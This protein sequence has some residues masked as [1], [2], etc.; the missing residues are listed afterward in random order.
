[1]GGGDRERAGGCSSGGV[2]R[3]G[4]W[5]GIGCKGRGNGVGRV[6]VG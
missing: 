4:G 5:W 2:G 1:M 3:I 6:V